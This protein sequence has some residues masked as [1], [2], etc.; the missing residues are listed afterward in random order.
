MLKIYSVFKAEVNNW[1]ECDIVCECVTLYSQR[2][3]WTALC[4]C[5]AGRSA[6]RPSAGP[7]SGWL[8][9]WTRSA[10]SVPDWLTAV[11]F[12]VCAVTHNIHTTVVFIQTSALKHTNRWLYLLSMQLL[13]FLLLHPHS[14]VLLTQS[15]QFGLIWTNTHQQTHVNTAFCVIAV[16]FTT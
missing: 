15:A 10:R 13:K 11:L 14:F 8:Q 2:W 12:P 6:E 4:R 16:C 9:R 5:S 7:G 1:Y 3:L